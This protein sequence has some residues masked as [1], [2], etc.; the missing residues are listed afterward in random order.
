MKR[1]PWNPAN[2]YIECSNNPWRKIHSAAMIKRREKRKII[3]AFGIVKVG[4]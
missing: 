2:T 3:K 4:G 1:N